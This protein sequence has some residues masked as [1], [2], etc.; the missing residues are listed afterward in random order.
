MPTA[1]GSA[2]AIASPA[3]GRVYILMNKPKGVY[4]TNV[5]Q[6]EQRGAIDLPRRRLFPGASTR[7][8]ASMRSSQGPAAADQRRRPDQPPDPPSLSAW[9]RRTARSSTA[10]CRPR[11]SLSPLE[12]GI[13]LAEQGRPAGSRPAG[14]RSRSS[15]GCARRAS[16]RS[17]PREGRNRTIR[18]DAARASGTR[19]AT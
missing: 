5:A 18:L 16:W 7:S 3:T 10:A 14:A 13:W 4:S 12:K 15:S 1:S 11:P 9:R 6:G 17:L 8:A 19:W 2:C